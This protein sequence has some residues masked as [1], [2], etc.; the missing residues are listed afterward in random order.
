MRLGFALIVLFVAI[1]WKLDTS[2]AAVPK[3]NGIAAIVPV[4]WIAN[5]P[6]LSWLKPVVAAGLL[7]WVL[8]F[9][10]VPALLPAVVTAVAAGAVRNSQGDI[11]HHTQLPV[12]VLLA[13]WT[14]HLV[15]AIRSR[16]W[17]RFP[18]GSARAA[19]IWAIITI[20]AGYVASALVKLDDSSFRWIQK[21]PAI[22]VQMIKSNLSAY[23]SS[24][25]EGPRFEFNTV[26]APRFILENPN[27]ARLFFGTGLFL[28]LFA[29]LLLFN[30]RVARWYAVA[31]IAMH[32]GISLFMKIDFWS[33]L[34]LLLVFCV[35]VPGLIAQWIARFV[36]RDVRPAPPP[37]P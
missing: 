7:V 6:L 30:L 8:G 34:W 2:H 11:S 19:T 31:L 5:P 25:Q 10:P 17:L 29:F 20:G 32:A 28:E 3:P 9:A 18:Q 13:V 14:V 16:E 23:Y 33:H 26:T 1:V 35:N 27:I 15:F 4:G 12:M 37:P 24:L 22:A 36:R 21:V